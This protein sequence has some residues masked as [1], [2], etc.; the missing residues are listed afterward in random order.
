MI[1][2]NA[3][4]KQREMLLRELLAEVVV[5]VGGKSDETAIIVRQTISSR[6]SG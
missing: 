4:V 6:L 5:L 2:E 1:E 3:K